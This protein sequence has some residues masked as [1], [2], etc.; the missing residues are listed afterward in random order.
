MNRINLKAVAIGILLTLALDTVLGIGLLLLHG[1]DV[2][3]EGRSAEQVSQDLQAVTTSTSFLLT[4][5]ILGT[6]TTVAG[7]CVAARIAGRFPY[8]NGLGVGI[9]GALFGLLFWGE[10]PLWFNLLALVTVIPMALLGAHIAV[11]LRS[12][13][14]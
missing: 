13:Q 12:V 3:V 9:L 10:N 4:S 14:P 11:R 8:F 7:G 5:I 1:G 6:L 2:S